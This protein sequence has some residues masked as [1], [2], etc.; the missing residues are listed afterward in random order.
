MCARMPS[1]PSSNTWN[2]PHGPAPT[3]TTSDSIGAVLSLM[4][5]AH[6]TEAARIALRFGRESRRSSEFLVRELARGRRL[7][8]DEAV[9]Q[10]RVTG[11]ASLREGVEGL[12]ELLAILRAN[13]PVNR[14]ESGPD[15]RR[16]QLAER[17]RELLQG[18]LEVLHLL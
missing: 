14:A 11:V 4:T 1:R 5:G 6:Y 15:Q 8:L 13:G 10:R 16:H 7:H 2:R 12:V 17:C 18:I 3:M 9:V